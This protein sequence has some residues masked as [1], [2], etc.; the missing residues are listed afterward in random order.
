MA[1]LCHLGWSRVD[2]FRIAFAFES[3]QVNRARRRQV[4]NDY[5][6]LGAVW[7]MSSGD[8]GNGA[9]VTRRDSER[10][11]ECSCLHVKSCRSKLLGG[12]VG[13]VNEKD[14]RL[15]IL[16]RSTGIGHCCNSPL[17]RV[18]RPYSITSIFSLPVSII[19]S[20]RM[21]LPIP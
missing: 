17:L 6:L 19:V 18:S 13:E 11:T 1:H 14:L 12:F 21:P 10:H 20:D 4:E 7:E 3:R 2:C 8:K 5:F 9:A 15:K 16:A